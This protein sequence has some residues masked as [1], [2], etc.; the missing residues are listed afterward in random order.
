MDGVKD[1]SSNLS[2]DSVGS[3]HFS[4]LVLVRSLIQS[5]DAAVFRHLRCVV[6]HL[7][8]KRKRKRLLSCH[9]DHETSQK[10]VDEGSV[11]LRP[12][13]FSNALDIASVCDV[14]VTDRRPKTFSDD[15]IYLSIYCWYWTWNL[16]DETRTSCC[17]CC[18]FIFVGISSSR[19]SWWASRL[20]TKEGGR[21][22]LLLLDEATA[23][24]LSGL[25]IICCQSEPERDAWS[26]FL[27]SR[28][29]RWTTT[30]IFNCDTNWDLPK[31]ASVGQPC[32]VCRIQFNYAITCPKGCCKRFPIKPSYAAISFDL[33]TNNDDDKHRDRQSSIARVF[34]INV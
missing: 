19:S 30:T 29:G 34:I 2:F 28:L 8:K 27:L 25:S 24:G 33:N 3:F 5:V 14:V 18:Y 13:H 21:L 15:H 20:M 10:Q 26:P 4:L 6:S 7:R 12:V 9:T 11:R 1:I 22:L 17:C 31:S 23:Y 16:V 32:D